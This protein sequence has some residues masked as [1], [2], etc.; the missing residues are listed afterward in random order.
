MAI[1]FIACVRWKM[2]SLPRLKW[3]V[4]DKIKTKSFKVDEWF[5]FACHLR[6]VLTWVK[7]CHPKPNNNRKYEMETLT[8]SAHNQNLS[9]FGF[10]L[11]RRRDVFLPFVQ[12][13]QFNLSLF[14][15]YSKTS[16]DEK[17]S[18]NLSGVRIWTI[19]CGDYLILSISIAIVGGI[20]WRSFFLICVQIEMLTEPISDDVIKLSKKISL[21]MILPPIKSFW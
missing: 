13:E 8:F 11:W 1:K 9:Y 7:K 20:Y 17:L 3:K 21:L 4:C 18:Y 5:F 10:V 16:I 14:F 2:E 6:L 15:P 19:S 12:L